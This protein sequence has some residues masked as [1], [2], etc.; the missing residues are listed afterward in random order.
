MRVAASFLH[1]KGSVK[2]EPGLHSCDITST[3]INVPFTEHLLSYLG[4]ILVMSVGCSCLPL[5]L[6]STSDRHHAMS[7]ANGNLYMYKIVEG[8]LLYDRDRCLAECNLQYCT[9]TTT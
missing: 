6:T 7:A 3:R 4:G 1:M 9:Y 8:H 2:P 5:Q